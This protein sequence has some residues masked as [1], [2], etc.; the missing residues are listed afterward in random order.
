MEKLRTGIS[1]RGA[2]PE[3]LH[4]P[5]MYTHTP[6]PSVHSATKAAHHSIKRSRSNVL[7]K[8]LAN[9]SEVCGTF[10]SL[11]NIAGVTR[12]KDKR[13]SEVSF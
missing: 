6:S 5:T 3:G 4:P 10:D 9:S 2:H 8:K 1:L 12:I 7:R 11:S 13:K